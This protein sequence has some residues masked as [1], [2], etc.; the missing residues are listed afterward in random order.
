[1]CIYIDFEYNK[2]RKNNKYLQIAERTEIIL[3]SNGIIVLIE[4]KKLV[5]GILFVYPRYL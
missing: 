1:M 3:K 4:I 2:Q 5:V